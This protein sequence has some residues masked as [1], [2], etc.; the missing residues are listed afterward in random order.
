MSTR[1]KKQNRINQQL[2]QQLYISLL[3]I[4]QF[5]TIHAIGTYMSMIR[6]MPSV[7]LESTLLNLT[8]TVSDRIMKMSKL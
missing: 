7:V 4:I 1:I 3:K 2:I 6:Q 8:G 5:H